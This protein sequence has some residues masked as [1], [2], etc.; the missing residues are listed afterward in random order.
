MRQAITDI[1]QTEIAK[2]VRRSVLRMLA[3]SKASHLGSNMSVIE[4]LIAMYSSVDCELIKSGST[5][6]SRVV[7]S[8]AIVRLQL[9]QSYLSLDYLRAST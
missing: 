1:N 5:S 4:I 2:K 3:S 8:K 9:M 7:V 6:R